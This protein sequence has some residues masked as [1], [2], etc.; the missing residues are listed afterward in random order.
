MQDVASQL[1]DRV[2]GN[3]LLFT[4]QTDMVKGALLAIQECPLT[5]LITLIM[6]ALT[7]LGADK[8]KGLFAS[9]SSMAAA[10]R[11]TTRA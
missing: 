6:V 5:I 10:K 3:I 11:A 2:A 7:E 4:V 8:Q 1:A 9:Q